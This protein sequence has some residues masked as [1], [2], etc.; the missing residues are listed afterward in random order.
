MVG[1]NTSRSVSHSQG[2]APRALAD[3]LARIPQPSEGC[4]RDGEDCGNAWAIGDGA[5]EFKDKYYPTN[6]K[7]LT[8]KSYNK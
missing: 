3:T 6:V 2:A 4:G 5:E 1:G 7:N 8:E